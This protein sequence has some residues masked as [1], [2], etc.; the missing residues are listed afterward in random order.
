[1]ILRGTQPFTN[2]SLA[3][4]D[5]QLPNEH[6]YQNLNAHHPPIHLGYC[7]GI[8]QEGTLCTPAVYAILE[9]IEASDFGSM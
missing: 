7:C 2:P 5:Y 8:M 9:V 6:E 4:L 1:M 3:K